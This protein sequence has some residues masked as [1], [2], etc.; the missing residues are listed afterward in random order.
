MPSSD[1]VQTYAPAFFA[2]AAS[3]LVDRIVDEGSVAAVSAGLSAPV[4]TFSLLLALRDGP[5]AVTEIA[6]RMKVTHAAVIKQ[7]KP[8]IDAQFVSRAQDPADR[9]RAPLKLTAKGRRES[10]RVIEFTKAAQKTYEVI[11]DEIGSDASDAI[12]RIDAAL[13]R[14]SFDERMSRHF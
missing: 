8:L 7:A 12:S 10:D 6:A 5:L 4:R 1:I 3:R 2:L 11:F 9:R 14:A 13:D